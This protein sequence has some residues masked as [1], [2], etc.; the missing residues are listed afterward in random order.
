M[1]TVTSKISG[2]IISLALRHPHQGLRFG[3]RSVILILVM[4]KGGGKKKDIIEVV[5]GFITG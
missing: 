2:V 1:K 5:Y 4:E 3:S